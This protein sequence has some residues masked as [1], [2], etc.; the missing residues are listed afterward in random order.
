MVASDKY[1]EWTQH[2]NVGGPCHNAYALFFYI[3]D[4]NKMEYS[5]Y[6]E[7]YVYHNSVEKLKKTF[8]KIHDCESAFDIM[9]NA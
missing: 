9:L 2:F 8:D 4:G 7:K 3:V 5:D 6:Y 1:N